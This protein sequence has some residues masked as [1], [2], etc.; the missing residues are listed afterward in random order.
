MV[1]RFVWKRTAGFLNSD[2]ATQYPGSDENPAGLDAYV[3]V[4]L[5]GVADYSWLIIVY[6][7]MVDNGSL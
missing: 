2:P 6:I 7:I 3:I 1:E 4:K 5:P